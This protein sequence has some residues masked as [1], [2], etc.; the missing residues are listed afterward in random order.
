MRDGPWISLIGERSMSE[1]H[2]LLVDD[3]SDIRHLT[4]K[5]LRQSGFRVTPVRD[6]REMREVMKSTQIDLVI[7]DLMLPGTSGL[8]LCRELRST[9]SI[10]IVILTARGEETD[11]VVG[12][13]L[14]ADDYLSKPGSPREL[15][16]RI[17]AVLRR[18]MVEPNRDHEKWRFVFE[19][20]TLDSRRRE[21]TDSRGV[22]IDLSSSE[23]DLLL[24]FVEAPQRVL[25][26]EHLLDSARNR[27]ST[28][29]DRAI[30]V[31]I[32]RLRRKLASCPG[33]DDIIK[34]IRGA[35]YMF[36]PGVMRA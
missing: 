11:R 3:D 5:F 6:G 25:T 36:T 20:W 35:G 10:P 8:D 4:S 18:T 33:G 32:S 13:E 14:G 16:A 15:A 17:R 22:V 34:T 21:L 2:V 1:P 30:D 29:F 26:R 27:I 28:G 23:Y 9:S 7:L 24:T 31:Q 19:G 12:L